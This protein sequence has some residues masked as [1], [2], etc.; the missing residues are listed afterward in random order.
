MK[1][2]VWTLTAL[3]LLLW[4]LGAWLLAKLLQGLLAW[5]PAE[6]LP[7]RLPEGWTWPV[8][9]DFW[10]PR[11]QLHALTDSLLGLVTWMSGL[12]PS[13]DTW[14]SLIGA[15]VWVLWFLGAAVLLLVAGL[16]HAWLGRRGM[17]ATART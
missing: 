2:L 15:G 5:W 8:W 13:V 3:A 1:T 6:G 9:V 17:K 4:S 10:W 14:Q 7:T 11:E 16:L 12:M